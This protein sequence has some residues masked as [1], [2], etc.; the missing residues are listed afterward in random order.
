MEDQITTPDFKKIAAQLRKPEGA[1]GIKV[2]ERMNVGNKSMNLHAI[3][4]LDPQ[5]NETIL[6]IGMGNGF[7]VKNIVCVGEHINY[8]GCDYSGDMVQ[9]ASEIN[10]D[11]IAQGQVNFVKADIKDLPFDTA[12]FDKI[13]TI[14]TFYFWE[15]HVKVLYELKRVLKKE[16]ELIIA[17]RPK[18]NLEKFP[19]TKYGFSIKSNDEI[20]EL[21]RSNGFNSIESTA[22]MEPLQE[23]FVAGHNERETLILSCKL[24]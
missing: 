20:I 19:V 1:D 10:K 11:F 21:L 7:F 3:A 22:I 15:D 6:E 24:E 9:L 12:R 17:V 8:V 5:A 16:G 4:V 13:I 18:H 23:G 14:N 2:A